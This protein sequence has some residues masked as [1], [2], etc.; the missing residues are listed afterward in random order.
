MITKTQKEL[1]ANLK[2]EFEKLNIPQQSSGL[3]DIASIKAENNPKE[4][5]IAEVK[6]NNAMIRKILLERMKADVEKLQ[7][8]VGELNMVARISSEEFSLQMEI[9]IQT[10]NDCRSLGVD[11]ILIQYFVDHSYDSLSGMTLYNGISMGAYLEIAYNDHDG[12]IHRKKNP[13]GYKSLEELLKDERVVKTIKKIYSSNLA[14][15]VK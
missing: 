1:L 7:A 2:N 6:K 9:I 13:R 11:Y 5:R 12:S 14:A 10:K 15:F 8:E 4:I 3:I